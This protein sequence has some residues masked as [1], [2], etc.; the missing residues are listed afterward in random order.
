MLA[1]LLHA[2]R[3]L[4]TSRPI[5][6]RTRS[7]CSSRH[8][9]AGTPRV[10]DGGV[11]V[12]HDRRIR[13]HESR[14]F[15]R[16]GTT[17]D[18]AFWAKSSCRRRLARCRRIDPPARGHRPRLEAQVTIGSLAQAPGRRAAGL[19]PRP[20]TTPITSGIAALV[21][22]HGNCRRR[23]SRDGRQAVWPM[24]EA[25]R[26]RSPGPLSKGGPRGLVDRQQ[27]GRNASTALPRL[28]F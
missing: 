13:A 9:G 2:S 24:V 22:G 15:R 19:L 14:A 16:R 18:Q 7:R 20:S 6:R 5:A 10:G 25:T 8:R 1:G 17:T 28:R 4:G 26:S 11:G 21:G 12:R 23:G 27:Q 3:S